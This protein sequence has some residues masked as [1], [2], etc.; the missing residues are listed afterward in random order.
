VIRTVHPAAT[1]WFH[2][3][4][5]R[6]PFIRAWG[7]S[8]P[9]ARH[10]GRLA[11]MPFRLMRWPAGTGPNW[12]NHAYPDSGSFVVELPRGRLDSGT[13]GRLSTALVRMGRWVRE[14]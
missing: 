7:H 5:G 3:Y 14:D 6:R 1:I 9:G 12:Q 2:Q 8:A 11:R 4:R 13:R 10:F